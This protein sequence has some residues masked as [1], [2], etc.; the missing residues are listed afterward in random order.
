MRDGNRLTETIVLNKQLLKQH[1]SS[2]TYSFYPFS[3]R[4]KSEMKYFCFELI[5]NILLSL[6]E[7][8]ISK[9]SVGLRPPGSAGQKRESSTIFSMERFLED[10]KKASMHSDAS[11]E[12]FFASGLTD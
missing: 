12:G 3:E 9:F 11:S 4:L 10:Q 6:K 5:F 2:S 1:N 7:T 8:Y